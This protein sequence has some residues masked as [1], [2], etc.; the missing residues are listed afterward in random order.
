MAVL[1]AM[2]PRMRA[3]NIYHPDP[4]PQ[5]ARAD[6]KAPTLPCQVLPESMTDINYQPVA[7]LTLENLMTV[8]EKYAVKHAKVVAAQAILETGYFSS[9]LC[10]ESHNLFGLR[11]P[12]DG[13]YYTFDNWEQS[14]K[15]YLDDVQ[16]K[17]TGG[18]YYAF[19]RR[20]GYAEDRQYTSKVR[21]IADRL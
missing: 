7:E 21:K 14:V 19:L 12:S 9:T 5:A 3:Q 16:Y 2:A 13:S 17:Y 1:A 8:L 15:A 6:R 11:H 10:L 18:D 20:I 4:L